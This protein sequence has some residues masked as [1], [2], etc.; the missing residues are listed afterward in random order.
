[1]LIVLSVRS[2]Y[3][4]LLVAAILFIVTS[5]MLFVSGNTKKVV[6]EPVLDPQLKVVE[7]V[8]TNAIRRDKYFTFVYVITDMC[9]SQLY[10]SG[11]VYSHVV[12]DWFFGNESLD[13]F[14]PDVLK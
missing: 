3:V 4:S 5:L 2:V 9:F 14:L 10:G 6:C 1:M 7:Q 11:S 8:S 13:I 12:G